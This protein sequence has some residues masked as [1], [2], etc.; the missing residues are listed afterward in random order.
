MASATADRSS[1]VPSSAA[2]IGSVPKCGQLVAALLAARVLVVV[3][4]AEGE[5]HQSQQEERAE[6]TPCVDH[7]EEDP[8]DHEQA[9]GAENEQTGHLQPELPTVIIHSFAG[10]LRRPWAASS[11]RDDRGPH[12]ARPSMG[13]LSAF[14]L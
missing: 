14:G 5:R 3:T 11:L 1:G 6:E 8:R 7:A 12:T 2:L 9:D 10:L 13:G 4:P